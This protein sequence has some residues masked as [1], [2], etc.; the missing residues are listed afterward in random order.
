MWACAPSRRILQAL[1]G[2]VKKDRSLLPFFELTQIFSSVSN[3]AGPFIVNFFPDRRQDPLLYMERTHNAV[4]FAGNVK[5]SVCA[6]R[7]AEG[8]EASA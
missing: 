4:H 6:A 7:I 5:K 3:N 2:S 8:A 1:E